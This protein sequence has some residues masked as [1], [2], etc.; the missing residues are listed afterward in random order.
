[1]AD[2]NDRLVTELVDAVRELVR[3]EQAD[4]LRDI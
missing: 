1:M 4:Q 2:I 3:K